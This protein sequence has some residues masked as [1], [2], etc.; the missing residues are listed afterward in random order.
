M[1]R[2]TI[3]ILTLLIATSSLA[4]IHTVHF[5]A[6]D[7]AFIDGLPQ[8]QGT[9]YGQSLNLYVGDRSPAGGGNAEFYV[10]FDISELPVSA[11]ILSAEL[12]LYR[13]EKFG[14]AEDQLTLS[15]YTITTPGWDENAI[16]WNAPPGRYHLPTDTQTGTFVP[17]G[18]TY[19]NVTPD[20]IGDHVAGTDAGWCVEMTPIVPFKWLNFWSG[21]QVPLPDYRPT[22]EVV[23]SGP[24]V[25]ESATW[26]SVKRLY[27]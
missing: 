10:Q 11:V 13:H 18:W 24:V 27:R 15:V 1:K 12:W 9:N 22:L 4:Q 8:N 26:G 23:Y 19:F 3:L 7:D 21:E 20:V 5:K 14:A 6:T 17:P 25:N 16:T 2:L